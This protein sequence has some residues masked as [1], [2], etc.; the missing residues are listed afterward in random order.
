MKHF[1]NLKDIPAKDLRKI[2]ID[3]KKRKN[4]RKNLNTLEVDKGSPLKGKML[5]QMFEKASSR[6]RISFYLA[7][8]QL[9]GGTLTLRSNELHLGQGGESISDTAKILSTYGDGFMLRTDSDKKIE[10]FKKYLSI[11]IINGLSPSSHP[12]Q[13]LSDVFTVEEIKKKPIS[14]LNIC[15][16]GDS[17]NV[18]DSLIAASVKFSFKLSIGCPKNF[19]PGKEVR[20]WVKN[21]NKKIFI[22]NDPKKA[23]MGADVIFSD[24]VISLNDKGNKKKKIEQFKKFKIDKK[25]MSYANKDCIFLHCLPRGSEVSD[26]VFLGKKSHVWQQALNRVHVQKSILLYCFGNLR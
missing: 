17:N 4:L 5:I 26:E 20:S 21:N 7:I 3:A 22:Y 10:D 25:L 8:K 2:I 18:L 13:V 14:K 15:W 1:I 24:K 9:G 11:P 19:E 16:I 6:T 12:T 23:V